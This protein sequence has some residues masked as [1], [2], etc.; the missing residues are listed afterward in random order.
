VPL[1]STSVPSAEN[2][3]LNRLIPQMVR[4]TA[5]G[6]PGYARGQSKVPERL[7]ELFGAVAIV[8]HKLLRGC[9]KNG[10]PFFA[11]RAKPFKAA[12]FGPMLPAF[13]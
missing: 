11:P 5:W 12:A 9:I 7:R 4:G 1:F 13:L 2:A 10:H 8:P 3:T 6:K